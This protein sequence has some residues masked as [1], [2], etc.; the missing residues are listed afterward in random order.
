MRGRNALIT[1]ATSGIGRAT[2]LG[3]A[4]MGATVGVVAR[5]AAKGEQTVAQI[6]GASIPAASRSTPY[7]R[8]WCG[9]T[10][11]GTTSPQP[12]PS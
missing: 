7:T 6:R 3:L 12:W 4:K 8:G 11:A 9:P 10:S 1:G 2:A 5:D